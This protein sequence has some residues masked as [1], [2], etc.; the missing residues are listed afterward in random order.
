MKIMIIE[1]DIHLLENYVTELE[2]RKYK[3]VSVTDGAKALASV[4]KEKPDLILLDIMLPNKNGIDI[5]EE[6]RN[7]SKIS[8]TLVVML[9]NYG[10]EEN[11]RRSLELGA[12]DYLKKYNVTP[13]DVGQRLEKYLKS[14]H[15]R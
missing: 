10:D 7:D 5:L 8:D 12:L 1:D 2:I 3:V 4:L 15:E 14:A 13:S 6:I 9:T 11:I